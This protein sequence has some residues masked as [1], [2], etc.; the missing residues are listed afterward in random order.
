MQK[1]RRLLLLPAALLAVCLFASGAAAAERETLCGVSCALSAADFGD[2]GLRGV[3]F[4]GVPS[5]EAG[6]L[7]CGGR[8]VLPGDA[9]CA[10]ALATLEF[11][12]CCN[13]RTETE[14]SYLPVTE[15]GIGE[16]Q[17]L[18]FKIG[19]GKDE[20]PTAQDSSLETYKNIPN[21]G[22]LEATDP[23]GKPLQF[24]VASAPRRG[25]VE[26][27]PDGSY[28]YTPAKNKVGEDSFTFT[29]TDPA[30]NVSKEATVNIKILKPADKLR[31]GDMEDDPDQFAALWLH[32][33]GAY[34][35]ESVAGMTCFCPE[36][37]VTRGEFLVMASKLTGLPPDDSGMASGFADEAETAAWMRPYIVSAL[38]AGVISGTSTA[39]GLVFR[40]AANL[41]GAEAAVIL[42][43]ILRLPEVKDASAFPD[44][45]TVP[46]WAEGAVSALSDAGVAIDCAAS[47]EP[48]TRR[49]AAR[50]L[51]AACH[52]SEE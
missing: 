28:T 25:T 16:S 36:K 51:Y 17:T 45:S 37:P 26:L 27:N 2:E 43:N 41:T 29:A 44:D 18:R 50:L 3:F 40:P 19:S 21:S 9:L 15:N 24:T 49:E 22:V 1:I 11:V 14:V 39:D 33:N 46:V 35:G 12:P 4:T 48:V 42:K 7:R 32:S 20:P 23:E 10:D 38:R 34:S 30:G 47:A 8:T 52:I 5:A 6:A 13:E 31:F